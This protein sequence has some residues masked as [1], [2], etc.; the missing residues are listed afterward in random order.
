MGTALQHKGLSVGRSD[1]ELQGAT[2]GSQG[3]A[4]RFSP[5]V[6]KA[7]TSINKR[8]DYRTHPKGNYFRTIS[9]QE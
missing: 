1:K 7:I 3:E 9:Q 5:P 2:T 8:L 6:I 4:P